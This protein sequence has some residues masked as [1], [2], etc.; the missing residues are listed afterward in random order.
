MRIEINAGGLGSALS[1]VEYQ[2]GINAV[3]ASIDGIISGFK[4]VRN[5][6]L[7]LHGGI[8]NLYEAVESLDA[9]IAKEEEKKSNAVEVKTKTVSFLDLAVRVDKQVSALVNINKDEFYRVNPWLKPVTSEERPWYQKAWDWL[10]GTGEKITSGMEKAANWIKDTAAKAWNGLVDFYEKHKKAIFTALLLIAAVAVLLLVP[11]AGGLLATMLI[12]AA[13]GAIAGAVIGG[14][15]GGMQ[16]VASGGS[17]WEGCENGAFSGA[18]GGAAAGAA[19]A[20]IGFAG[21]ALGHSISAFSTL[22][23]AIKVASTVTTTLSIGMGAFDTLALA[24]LI[25]DPSHNPV[26]DLNSQAHSSAVY[27][28][29][30][31]GIGVLATF[32]GG[33]ASTLNT[34]TVAEPTQYTSIGEIPEDEYQLISRYNADSSEFNSPLR[35]GATTRETEQFGKIIDRHSLSEDMVLYRRG[36]MEEIVNYN[37]TNNTFEF[38]G[39]MSTTPDIKLAN[40]VG[41]NGNVIFEYHVPKGT[42]G[43]DLSKTNYYNEVI[44]NGGIRQIHSVTKVGDIYHIICSIFKNV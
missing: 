23:K 6:T 24:D 29:A 8:G 34:T 41:G 3:A 7:N 36:S 20:G 15:S 32:T 18:L 10:C 25:I 11:P 43:L 12:G 19:F 16:S 5:S 2:V 14:I 9:R 28:G 44:F 21:Q 42:V 40:S 22:G 31:I 35:N 26:F 39:F 37:A 4:S 33:M 30:Q 17:F 27:N 13:W 38:Q 1:V